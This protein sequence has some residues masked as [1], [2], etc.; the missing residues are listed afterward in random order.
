M[1]YLCYTPPFFVRRIKYKIA[2]TAVML[3][4]ETHKYD[5]VF[6]TWLFFFLKITFEELGLSG[7]KYLVGIDFICETTF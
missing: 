5:E 4:I 3:K 6:P 2:K 7:F 1:Q